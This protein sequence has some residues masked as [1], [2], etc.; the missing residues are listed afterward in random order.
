[1]TLLK[2]P[3][4]WL[5]IAMSVVALIFTLAWLAIFGIVREEDEGIAAHIFQLLMGGQVPIILFFAVK[6]LPQKP[7]LAI[8]VMVLQFIT[9]LIAFAPVYFLEL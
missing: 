1:M 6:W 4:A 5:P 9:G 7:K 3:S 8:Q 2:K